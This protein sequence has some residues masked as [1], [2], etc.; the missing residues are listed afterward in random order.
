[1][2]NGTSNTRWMQS[3]SATQ[4]ISFFKCGALI[5]DCSH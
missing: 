5:L 2:E 4:P 3:L 1:M